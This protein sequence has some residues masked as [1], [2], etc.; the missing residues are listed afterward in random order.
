MAAHTTGVRTDFIGPLCSLPAEEVG[1]KRSALLFVCLVWEDYGQ[2]VGVPQRNLRYLRIAFS[3]PTHI[4]TAFSRL[5]VRQ[6]CCLGTARCGA[7]FS[8]ALRGPY[9][10]TLLARYLRCLQKWVTAET[11]A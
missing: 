8:G 10:E 5:A 9:E 11:R 1:H 7:L 4:V 3:P 6:S 2:T